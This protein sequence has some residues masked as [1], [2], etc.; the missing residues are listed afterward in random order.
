VKIIVGLGNPGTAYRI[1]RHNI[2][3]Q[4]VDRLA[5]ISHLSIHTRRFRSL[6]GTGCIN[7]EQ[8]VLAKPMTFMN[9]SGEAVK[10]AA[11]FFHL[12]VEDLVVVHDDLDLPFGRLRFKRRGGAGGHQG[13]RSII[14]CMG[15]NNFL[16]LKVGIGR[17]PEGM[18]PAEYV[19]DV[20]D[21]LEQSHLDQILSRAAESLRVMLL[22]GL[23]NA[24][25]QFQKK[26][27]LSPVS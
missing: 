23:E 11:D 3:F 13:V 5:K 2:G 22:E 19:L 16:R 7:S 20:F 4:V 6:Y 18:D 25:N 1:S 8:V 12:K 21:N 26:F 10:K 9:R 15:G 17:P 27:S 24:V 14:E